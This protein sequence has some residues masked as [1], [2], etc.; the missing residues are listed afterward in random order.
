MRSSIVASFSICLWLANLAIAAEPKIQSD[1]AGY[2]KKV[3]PFL[4]KYC[5]KCHSGEK[6][7]AEFAVDS[8]RLANLFADAATREKWREVVNVLNAHEMPPEK[9][10]QPSL[11]EV[12]SVVDWITEQT[13]QAELAKRERSVVLRRLNRE[14]YRNTIRD[15]VGVE[16]DVSG[17]PQDPPAG[18][19]DNNGAALTGCCTANS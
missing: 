16:F 7:E 17:F 8:K 2:E 15:L 12:V 9:E 13:V 6:P 14:E 4:S 10:L 11:E 19:F 18:G 3:A 1:R 5:Q